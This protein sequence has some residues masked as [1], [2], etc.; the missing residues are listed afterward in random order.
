MRKRSSN[1]QALVASWCYQIK[2]VLEFRENPNTECIR[3]KIPIKEQTKKSTG[4]HLN[5][6]HYILFKG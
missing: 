5:D 2:L 6:L 1:T 4:E 3:G